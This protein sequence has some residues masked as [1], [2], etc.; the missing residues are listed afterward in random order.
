MTDKYDKAAPEFK[1]TVCCWSTP[2]NNSFQDIEQCAAIGAQGVGLWERKIAPDEY[3]A[4]EEALAKHNIRA[5]IV[6]PSDW[7]IIPVPLNPRAAS[8][9]WKEMC[10]SMVESMPQLAQLKPV[11]VLVGPGPAAI[12]PI[13]LRPQRK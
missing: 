13:P 6:V 5:G 1:Y 3:G 4:I 2:N 7:T 9:T 10:A 8:M 11:G 12:L